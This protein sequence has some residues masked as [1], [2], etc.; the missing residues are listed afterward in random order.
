[1]KAAKMSLLSALAS[2]SFSLAAQANEVI[3]TVNKPMDIT[4][5]VAHA[6]KDGQVILSDVQKRRIDNATNIKV[7]KGKFDLAGIVMVSTDGKE[8]PAEITKFNQPRQCSMT[9]DKERSAGELAITLSEH[10]IKC[11]VSGG[12]FG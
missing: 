12:V 5:R 3:I 11:T 8:L 9:T 7:D 4:Y 6:M 1:M 2:L 10:A